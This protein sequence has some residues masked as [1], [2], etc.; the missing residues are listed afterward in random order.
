MDVILLL[1]VL[2]YFDDYPEWVQK[3][4]T[5]LNP[6]GVVIATSAGSHCILAKAITKAGIPVKW[7]ELDA[8]ESSLR[9]AYPNI[10]SKYLSFEVAYNM[11]HLDQGTLSILL[12][13]V[14]SQREVEDVI[15]CCP[16][17]ENGMLYQEVKIG[18]Y[19]I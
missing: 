2:Y 13:R 8:I 4:M 17:D 9:N 12:L 11:R 5:W 1:D 15:K 19:S 14:A 3:W 10:K 6:G 18:I 7:P 16:V